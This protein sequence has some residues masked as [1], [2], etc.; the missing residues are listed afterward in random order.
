MGLNITVWSYA[1]NMN[2]TFVGCMKSL[3]DID[4][5]ANAFQPAMAEQ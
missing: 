1:G 3:P 5:I 2:F 4:I